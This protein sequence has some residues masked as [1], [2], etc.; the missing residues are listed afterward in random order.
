M[1]QYGGRNIYLPL[2]H[3]EIDWFGKKYEDRH[4]YNSN[5]FTQ[6]RVYDY[7][8]RKN[9][10]VYIGNNA[11]PYREHILTCMEEKGIIVDRYGS[12]SNPVEDKIAK[13]SE[14]KVALVFENSYYPGYMTEKLIHAHLAGTNCLYWGGN[15]NKSID[16]N[17]NHI[18]M[19]DSKTN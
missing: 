17:K 6:S 7:K 5:I 9:R 16:I 8:E 11:E 12:Q 19:S 10:V 1:N 3:L 13:L 18:M 4:T 2:W 15:T 14:Y